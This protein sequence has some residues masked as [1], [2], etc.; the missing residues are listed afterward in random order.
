MCS[1]A[2]L[3]FYYSAMNAGKTTTLLQSSHNY[4]ERGM[5]TL[6]FMASFDTRYG[7]KGRI[8]SRIGLEAEAV[9]FDTT[10]SFYDYVVA[11]QARAP[12][13]CV[14]VDEA[15]FLTSDQVYQLTDIVDKL[16]IPVLAY[17]LRSDFLGRPFEP[18]KLLLALAEELEEIKTICHCGR[19]ATMNLRIDDQGDPVW[20]GNQ[21]EVGGNTRYVSLCRM[22]FKEGNSGQIA[23]KESFPLHQKRA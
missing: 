8:I 10:F 1:M 9:T 15:H 22:H 5:R 23:P 11:E 6:L 18:S 3:Y 14:L 2:K 20:E 19:K 7:E 16:H 17:G 12:L 21:I 13:H 4:R